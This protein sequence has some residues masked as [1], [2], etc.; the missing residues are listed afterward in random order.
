MFIFDFI[1]KVDLNDSLILG[2]SSEAY[3]IKAIAHILT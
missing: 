1:I 2:I 3:L